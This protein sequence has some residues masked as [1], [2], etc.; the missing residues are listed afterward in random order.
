MIKFF[1]HIRQN[2]LAEN[3]TGKPALSAGRYFKYAIGEII[4]VVIG[5]L[6]ALQINNWN[7]N[8]KQN[9]RSLEYHQRIYEDLARLTEKG[10]DLKANA[11]RILTSITKTVSLLESKKELT[12]E[13]R[14]TVDFVMIWF[15]RT[16]YQ[17][18]TLSTYE[19]MKSNGDLNLIYDV[20]L[21]NQITDFYNYLE[22]VEKVYDKIS[23]AI[24]DD[25]S[26]FSRYVRTYVNPK[27]LAITHDYD[28]SKMSADE[29]FINTFSRLATH[30]R[31]YAYFL[32]TV[33]QESNKIRAG[34]TKKTSNNPNKK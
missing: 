9:N 16:T 11:D 29:E 24:E 17:L 25:Y 10:D 34:F 5:I 22:Q 23:M 27:T 13:D 12:S 32:K 20:K 2:L 28:F 21:R 15:S 33:N 4:L 31:G 18:P 6:I 8:R 3:K 1:R 19:E 26:V 14:K 7:E 30:W